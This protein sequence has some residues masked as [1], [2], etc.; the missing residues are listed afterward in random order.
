VTG[1]SGGLGGAFAEMLLA[2]GVAVWGS[3]RSVEHLSGFS[4]IEGFKSVV[5]D[6]ANAEQIDAAYRAGAEQAGGSFDLVVNNA[7]YGVFGAFAMT[8]FLVWR[9][10]LEATLVGSA[11]IAHL[12]MRSMVTNRHGCLVNISS[13][14]V[15][16][17]LP[18]M[19]GYNMA[20]A[21]LSALSESLMFETRSAG[22]TVIDFRPGDY[23][24]SFNHSMHATSA[25]FEPKPDLRLTRA[26]QTLE[27]NLAA[28]PNP[29]RAAADLR[30]AIL[31]GKSGTVYSGSF[32]QVKL[33]PL[34]ARLAPSRMRRAVSALYFGAD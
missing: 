23:R 30:K 19:A 6:L 27:A 33:A 29:K 34:F 24:T 22:V 5:L 3:A 31:R 10:L 28:A 13:V 25:A 15:E 14:A 8:P 20:K 4:K 2:D 21:G 7:S 12:A 16:Y 1:V 32:F 9:A 11:Q 26:W 18:F 17:P